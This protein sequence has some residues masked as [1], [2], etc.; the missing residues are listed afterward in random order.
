MPDALKQ[1][2]AFST[3]SRIYVAGHKGMVGS[4]IVR[5]LQSEG[6]RHILTRDRKKLDLTDQRAVREFF[7]NERIDAVFLAAARVGGIYAN[8][9]YPAEFIYQNL[10]IQTHLIHEAYRAGVERLLFLGSSCIYPKHAPQP[11]KEQY[12]LTGYLEPTNEPYAIAKI[13]GIKLCESYNRQY[14]TS[15]RSVMPTNLYGPEDNFD[16]ESS[17]VL[18]AM[19][20]KFH[21]AKLALRRAW[22]DIDKDEKQ[23]G[24]IPEDIRD[25][26]TVLS[27][28]QQANPSQK[29]AAVRLWGSGNPRRE[30]LHVDDAASA[31]LFVMRLPDEKY[32]AIQVSASKNGDLV[33]N[34]APNFSHINIGAGEDLTIKELAEI[35]KTAIGYEGY[36]TWDTSRPDGTPRKLLDVSRLNSMGW[37]AEINLAEGIQQTYRWYREQCGVS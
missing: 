25:S 13:A 6:Y 12:L 3:D 20:R 2:G 36:T 9:T 29:P 31:C 28:A 30:F 15:Y 32:N 1:T 35:V 8:N 24:R 37:K 22:G 33:T 16:L 10:L 34:T 7:R 5:R 18:P 26:L 27:R 21:L 23:F 14:G 11:L 4:A 17:H 19:V